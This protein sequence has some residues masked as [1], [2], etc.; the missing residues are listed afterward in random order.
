MYR[1]EDFLLD[2][3]FIKWV[4][5]PNKE[6]DLYWENWIAINPNAK[7]EF[8]LAREIVLGIR[9]DESAQLQQEEKDR[10]LSQ[11]MQQSSTLETNSNKNL[12]QKNRFF[13]WNWFRVAAIL[14]LGASLTFLLFQKEVESEVEGFALVEKLTNKGEKRSFGLPDG[15]RVWLNSNSSIIYP[16]QFTDSMRV[17]KLV[18]EAF[19]EV[20][21]DKSK[22]FK[23][24]SHGVITTALGT[25]FN[26][27]STGNSKTMV[28]LLTGSVSISSNT[29]NLKSQILMPYQKLDYDAG[30]DDFQVS[31][32]DP[33]SITGW[34]DG[35]LIFVNESLKDV[36][37]KLEL[38][39]GVQIVVNKAPNKKWSFSGEYVNQSLEV[40]LKS[41][42]FIEDFKFEINDKQVNIT[43]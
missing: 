41:M 18:G 43:F 11:I 42:S 14:V 13:T 17:V 6:L 12:G 36:M 16:E 10:I 33:E 31:S 29:P 35:K 21:E 28:A 26:V 34:K 7:S 32:F 3:E 5:S 9:F 25:S 38:W 1:K 20:F 24:E 15:T 19:F 2:P 40:V 37:E 27:R 22:P 30:K 23:V 39:Y 4:K 8:L